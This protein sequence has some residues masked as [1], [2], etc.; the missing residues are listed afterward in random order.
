MP[1]HATRQQTEVIQSKAMTKSLVKSQ[2]WK[3]AL[4]GDPR[5]LPSW[6]QTLIHKKRKLV[7]DSRQKIAGYR[8]LFIDRIL[9]WT[10]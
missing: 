6:V 1:N 9:F 10:T 7:N 4:S 5:A 8:V 2:R 3:K